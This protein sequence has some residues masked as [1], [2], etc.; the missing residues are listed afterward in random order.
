MFLSVEAP[1]DRLAEQGRRRE[2]LQPANMRQEMVLVSE[3]VIHTFFK[4]IQTRQGWSYSTQRTFSC[5]KVMAGQSIVMSVQIGSQTVHI[6]AVALA[7]V[8][9]KWITSAP[10]SE[11]P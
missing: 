5:A 4:M 9:E 8:S 1:A 2:E 10:G 6:T 7:A 3:P 11:A